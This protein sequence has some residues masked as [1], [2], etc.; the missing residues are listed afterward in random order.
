VRRSTPPAGET[1]LE[2][3]IHELPPIQRRS[4]YGVRKSIEVVLDTEGP[5]RSRPGAES[6][7]PGKSSCTERPRSARRCSDQADDRIDI[8]HTTLESF[9]T[10]WPAGAVWYCFGRCA[11]RQNVMDN[12]TA[13]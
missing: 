4:F 7:G 13:S 12:L 6:W 3:W 5:P 8:N 11:S 10:Y 9:R 2:C 1:M